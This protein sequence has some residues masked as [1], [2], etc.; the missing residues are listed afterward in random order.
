M[1]LRTLRF[2]VSR[3]ARINCNQHVSLDLAPW[4]EMDHMTEVTEE[5]LMQAI[6]KAERDIAQRRKM[7]YESWAQRKF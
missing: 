1:V 6:Q 4:L 2:F 7:E 5:M 3:N